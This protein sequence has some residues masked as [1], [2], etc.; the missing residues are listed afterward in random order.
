[1]SAVE[2]QDAC[3]ARTQTQLQ[4]LTPLLALAN[5]RHPFTF[6]AHDSDPARQRTS[7]LENDRVVGKPAAGG[8]TPRSLG[9]GKSADYQS[10][11][12]LTHAGPDPA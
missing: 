3:A 11:L 6:N 1:M 8:G 5:F 9:T 12:I 2:K 7:C 10:H 4:T